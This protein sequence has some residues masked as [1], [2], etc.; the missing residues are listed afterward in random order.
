[1]N[2]QENKILKEKID[3]FTS[4]LD[5]LNDPFIFI[6]YTHSIKLVSKNITNEFLKYI[7]P[8]LLTDPYFSN[9]KEHDIF[10]FNNYSNPKIAYQKYETIVNKHFLSFFK[11]SKILRIYL[12]NIKDLEKLRKYTK[13]NK[14]YT[15]QR[16]VITQISPSKDEEKNINRNILLKRHKNIIPILN[17]SE[18]SLK[19]KEEIKQELKTEIHDW[20]WGIRESDID[21]NRHITKLDKKVEETSMQKNYKGISEYLTD[22]INTN[23]QFKN[24][25]ANSPIF[26]KETLTAEQQYHFLTKRINDSKLEERDL[27]IANKNDIHK[28]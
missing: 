27:S 24:S 16:V 9:N 3:Y 28:L 5:K 6:E 26:F 23:D 12:Q 4:E 19:L 14:Y 25:L 20:R 11:Q 7:K 18:E 22:M 17:R 10:N 2:L 21:K 13:F 1:V 8:I 15:T